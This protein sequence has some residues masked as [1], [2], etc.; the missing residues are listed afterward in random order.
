MTIMI[1]NCIFYFQFPSNQGMQYNKPGIQQYNQAMQVQGMPN[2]GYS[3]QVQQSMKPNMRGQNSQYSS[4]PHQNQYYGQ[5]QMNNSSVP[6]S[7]P[8]AQSQYDQS[9]GNSQYPAAN[10]FHRGMNNYQHSPIPGNPT[11][12]LTPASNMP[13]YLSPSTD[14]KP[15]YSDIKPRMPTQSKSFEIVTKY[16]ND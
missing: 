15:S 14:V 13:P 11:P 8:N 12:P 7:H 4:V 1:I 10:N 9:Y 16:Q 6:S 3:N 5:N 2:V